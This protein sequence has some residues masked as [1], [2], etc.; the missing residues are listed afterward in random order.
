MTSSS[1]WGCSYNLPYKLRQ[2]IF[3]G[4]GCT[5]SH[6]TPWLCL[7]FM[8]WRE[9]V[10]G[11]R[12]ATKFCAITCIETQYGSTNPLYTCHDVRSVFTLRLFST[13]AAILRTLCTASKSNIRQSVNPTICLS[14]V[15]IY[16]VQLVACRVK[17][18]YM[19]KAEGHKTT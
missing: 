9:W 8:T 3:L 12:A 16:P 4:L 19:V 18:G 14:F 6:C 1:A 17:W 7:C 15:R 5:C 13:K 2:K 10:R 11:G